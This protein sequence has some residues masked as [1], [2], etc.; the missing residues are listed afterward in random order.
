MVLRFQRRVQKQHQ[1]WRRAA[2][3]PRVSGLEKPPQSQRWKAEMVETAPFNPELWITKS[4][5]KLKKKNK[6]IKSAVNAT[7]LQG[8][9]LS[10]HCLHLGMFFIRLALKRLNRFESIVD[11]DS[12]SFYPKDFL[13]HF[14]YSL[15][16]LFY[17]IDTFSLYEC[18]E[19]P[20]T[21][22]TQAYGPSLSSRGR[23]W[24]DTFKRQ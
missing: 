3:W 21:W 20:P 19:K 5:D 7:G 24:K 17:C 23:I 9:E 8:A 2:M 12:E 1:T 4:Q 10:T 6:Y 15:S 14:L 18:W 22:Y 16:H 11:L 13:L